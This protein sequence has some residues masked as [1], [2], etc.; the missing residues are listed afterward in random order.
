MSLD[1]YASVRYKCIYDPTMTCPMM[2]N[3]VTCVPLTTIILFIKLGYIYHR[4]IL[5]SDG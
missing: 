1:H 2:S 5:K 4:E 3:H